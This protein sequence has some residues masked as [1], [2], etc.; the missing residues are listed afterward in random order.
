MRGPSSPR[1]S[2]PTARCALRPSSLS[3]RFHAYIS[4]AR[5]NTRAKKREHAACHLGIA[6][7]GVRD[8]ASFA[9]QLV[10]KIVKRRC[11]AHDASVG[12]AGIEAT[13]V[14]VVV[15]IE[16]TAPLDPSGEQRV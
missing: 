4:N 7:V 11:A 5:S 8:A 12:R 6:C 16:H 2:Y 10:L 14:L 3:P 15:F 13:V 1:L 9:V